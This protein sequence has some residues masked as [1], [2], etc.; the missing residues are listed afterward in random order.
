MR[1]RKDRE[2]LSRAGVLGDGL[3]AAF[4][5]GGGDM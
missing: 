3:M 5:A 2:D 4:G 1:P